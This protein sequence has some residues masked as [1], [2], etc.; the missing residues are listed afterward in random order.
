MGFEGF[1]WI[2]PA[3]TAIAGAFLGAIFAAIG[4]MS[5]SAVSDPPSDGKAS[6]ALRIF[7]AAVLIDIATCGILWVLSSASLAQSDILGVDFR[8]VG[9][10]GNWIIGSVLLLASID[11]ARRDTTSARVLV[12][13]GSIVL[14]AINVLCLVLFFLSRFSI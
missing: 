6:T 14:F 13:T 8:S 7:T 4:W 1:V 3:L 12:M 10:T 9:L 5:L 2:I 11:H